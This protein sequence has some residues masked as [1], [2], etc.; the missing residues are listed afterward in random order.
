MND[1]SLRDIVVGLG[2]KPNGFLREDGFMITVA[3]EIMAILCL[4]ENLMDL[5]ER[6]GKIL[7]A[8]DLQGNPVYCKDLCVNGA[9]ALLMKDAIK[10]NLVQTLG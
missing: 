1:R 10:P 6:M 9:M 2:G 5:K 8:Y 3:S 4:S 7:I